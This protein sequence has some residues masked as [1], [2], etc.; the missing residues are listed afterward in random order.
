MALRALGLASSGKGI[1]QLKTKVLCATQANKHM[2]THVKDFTAEVNHFL[3]RIILNFY[4]TQCQ[5]LISRVD[6]E[7]V[8][9]GRSWGKGSSRMR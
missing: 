2:Y 7:T 6:T 8:A 1:I 3:G 5:E 4:M 9:A